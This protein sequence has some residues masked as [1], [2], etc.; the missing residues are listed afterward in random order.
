[1]KFFFFLDQNIDEIQLV[2]VI[3][4][5]VASLLFL[6]NILILVSSR[7]RGKYK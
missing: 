4:G 6:I 5:C 7:A 1:M 3:L 2:V